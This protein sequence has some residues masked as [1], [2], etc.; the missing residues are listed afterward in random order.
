MKGNLLK[1][2]VI[3]VIVLL[4][5]SG[6]ALAANTNQTPVNPS[7]NEIYLHI[8]SPL[9]LA[10]DQI[11][12]LDPGNLDVAATVV[13][14]RTLVPMRAVSEYF[15]AEVSY[16]QANKQAVIIYEGK[17]Y[18][19]SMNQAKY[20]VKDATGSKTVAMDTQSLILN[21]RTMLP[22]RVICEQI[23]G[24]KVAYYNQVIAI[25]DTKIMLDAEP[26]LVKQVKSKIGAALK[27]ES[28]SQL[29][30]FLTADSPI[31]IMY[32][33]EKSAA[34]DTVTATNEAAQ[35]SLTSDS[36]SDDG[37]YSNTNVQVAGIDEAD[38]V[39]TDG[40]YIYMGSNNV[41]RIVRAD[42]GEMSDAAII[43]YPLNQ[44]VNEIYVDGDRLVVLG[45]K[46]DN[47]P[48][49]VYPMA[50]DMKIAASSLIY[51]IKSYSF[52]DVYDISDPEDPVFVKSHEMEGNYQTSRKNG[53]VVYMITNDYIYN[54]DDI[55][56]MMK[57][58]ATGD[59]TTSVKLDD[60]MI[61]P[62]YP[63]SG[64]IIVSA[65]DVNDDEA[66]QV[67]AIAATGYIYYMND[68]ALYIAGTDYNGDTAAT[69]IVKM[70]L[71]G[72]N[73]G[74]AGSGTVSGY[75]NNQFS[76]DEKDGYL[77][78]A[79]STWDEDNSLYV[80]DDSLNIC[81][82]VEGFAEG[83]QI[84][85]VRYFGDKGYVVTFKTIDPLF[86]FDLSDPTNP[87][88]TGEVTLPGFSDYLHPV[89]E[90]QILGIG[91]DTADLY[92]KD[93]NGK[94]TVVGIRQTGLKFT[95]FDVSEMADPE[96]FSTYVIGTSGTY[97]EA[98]YNH[99]AVMVDSDRQ[100]IAL[101]AWVTLDVKGAESKQKAIIMN[102]GDSKL[103]LVGTL[104]STATTAYGNDIPYGRRLLYIGDTLYYIQ[105]NILAS[106]QYSTL[107]PIDTFELQ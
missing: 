53:D 13:N 104:D 5:V 82:S 9:V 105:D 11:K 28:L 23:L 60:V 103:R 63:A 75:L 101:D 67:E 73:M 106:Y 24:K 7:A 85:S 26:D 1:Y 64:Y 19:F 102:Y 59:E 46:S 12:A 99:K 72:T 48:G 32:G 31:R 93:E 70:E 39:K 65:V 50:T 81:G 35:N 2:T 107:D 88:I 79:T 100:N 89:G 6:I 62:A 57:D 52:M 41:V 71:D 83:E 58:T 80:L 4:T 15:G 16:D 96:V 40:Q 36:A 61:M 14:Y 34:S 25:S 76:M 97:S 92:M 84:Y 8:D 27:A 45:S 95:L 44:Y 29:R 42:S 47:N 78:V 22:L 94:E 74:Y 21:N 86:V 77:R 56:P 49:E 68:S 33:T 38:I 66:A 98:L 54:D 69:S 10:D 90:D 17:Q 20:L 37:G 30:K 43:R 18:T 3:I 87:K 51:P 91:M 55:L